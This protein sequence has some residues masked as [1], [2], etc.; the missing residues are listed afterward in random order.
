MKSRRD[1]E[2]YSCSWLDPTFPYPT[3]LPCQLYEFR[4]ALTLSSPSCFLFSFSYC[5]GIVGTGAFLQ[6]FKFDPSLTWSLQIVSHRQELEL[7]TLQFSLLKWI[8]ILVTEG[9]EY[10]ASFQLFLICT[11]STARPEDA[12]DEENPL[13]T[14][15]SIIVAKI[16]DSA[17]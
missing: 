8:S 4:S 3:F 15:K 2:T 12:V 16:S 9:W 1:H 14:W 5:L 10:F 17:I 13:F 11:K 7:K 6:F